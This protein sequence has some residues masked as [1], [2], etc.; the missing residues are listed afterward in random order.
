MIQCELFFFGKQRLC[1]LYTR[2]V[3][4]KKPR[5]LY[6]YINI[7]IVAVSLTSESRICD[8]ARESNAR[9]EISIANDCTDV[10]LFFFFRFYSGPT[11]LFVQA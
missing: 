6:M 11:E 1:I 9:T 7:S 3:R 4:R 5:F 2:V 8:K 10:Y